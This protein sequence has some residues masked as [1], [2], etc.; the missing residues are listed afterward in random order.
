MANASR[1]GRSPALGSD[2]GGLSP[3]LLASFFEVRQETTADGKS[4]FWARHPD[5]VEVIAPITDAHAEISLSWRSPFEDAGPDQK[6]S[7]LSGLI[8]GGIL[9]QL[10][11]ELGTK[12]DSTTLRSLADRSRQYEGATNFSRLNSLQVFT[13]MPPLKLPV[14]AHFR[15][16]KDA[17]VE[18]KSPVDQLVRWSLPQELAEFG[19]AGEA[20]SGRPGLFPSTA[21]AKVGLRYGDLLLMPLVIESISVPVSG[22]RTRDGVLAYAA[23]TMQIATLAALDSRDWAIASA[24]SARTA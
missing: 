23:V 11:S 19:P 1:N 3:H 18:V 2:W 9:S 13:G 20:I 17:R 5:S 4:F 16:M 12:F 6:F 21:P 7:S 24:Y 22:Q 8:Q 10:L 14:T 15:A